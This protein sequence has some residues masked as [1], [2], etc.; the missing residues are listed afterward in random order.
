MYLL[1]DLSSSV[2]G[3]VVRMDGAELSLVRHPAVLGAGVTDPQWT[4]E[5]VAAAFTGELAG[6]VQPLGLFRA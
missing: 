1:S 6:C 5:A 4:V 2:H 3:Q